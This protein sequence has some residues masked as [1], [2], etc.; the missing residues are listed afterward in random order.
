MSVLSSTSRRKGF[1]PSNEITRMLKV[2]SST[3]RRK[4]FPP[5]AT[6]LRPRWF[7]VVY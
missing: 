7:V 5:V 3:S 2:L 1:P 6:V 4:G